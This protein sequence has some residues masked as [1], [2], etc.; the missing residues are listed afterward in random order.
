MYL[1]L[2]TEK[3]LMPGNAAL[4]SFD[5]V[6]MLI[7]YPHSGNATNNTMSQY[8]QCLCRNLLP[9]TF[10]SPMGRDNPFKPH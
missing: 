4:M 5:R 9:H 3:P 8:M 10:D 1:R 6:S 2:R 7:C